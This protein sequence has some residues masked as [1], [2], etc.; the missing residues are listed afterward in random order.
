MTERPVTTTDAGVPAAKFHR[1]DS[2]VDSVTASESGVA[3]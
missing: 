1:F 2:P 3:S